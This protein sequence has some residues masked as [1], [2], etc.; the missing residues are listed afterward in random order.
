MYVAQGC[1]LRIICLDSTK[2]IR[3]VDHQPRTASTEKNRCDL[4]TLISSNIGIFLFQVQFVRKK[5]NI[6]SYV[7]ENNVKKSHQMVH[8]GGVQSH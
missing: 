1:V 4:T 7:I 5:N 8:Q 2:H 3:C 6:I